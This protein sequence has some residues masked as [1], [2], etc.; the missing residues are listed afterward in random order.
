MSDVSR[1][2]TPQPNGL[3]DACIRDV[4]DPDTEPTYEDGLKLGKTLG[5]EKGYRDGAH[6]AYVR[7]RKIIAGEQ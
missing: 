5:Y 4:G 6:D 3:D 7:A 1:F 2:A